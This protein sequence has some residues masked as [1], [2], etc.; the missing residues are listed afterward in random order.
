MNHNV[1]VQGN[2]Q[3]CRQPLSFPN[4]TMALAPSTYDMLNSISDHTTALA[5]TGVAG[6]A[7]RSSHATLPTQWSAHQRSLY[8]QSISA[9]NSH[10]YQPSRTSAIGHTTAPSRGNTGSNYARSPSSTPSTALATA[11]GPSESFVVLDHHVAQSLAALP[12]S[13]SFNTSQ[14]HGTTGSVSPSQSSA[15]AVNKSDL[16]GLT[17]Q[18]SSNA[19]PSPASTATQASQPTA[20]LPLSPHLNQ[21]ANVYSLLSSKSSIDYPL[22]TECIQVL[23]SLMNK[24]LDEG[25][26][27]RERLLAFEKDVLKRRDEATSSAGATAGASPSPTRENLLKEIAKVGSTRAIICRMTLSLTHHD[28]LANSTRKPRIKPLKISKQSKLNVNNWIKRKLSWKKKKLNWRKKSNSQW[29]ERKREEFSRF[30]Q[31]GLILY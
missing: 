16:P 7:T 22:C 27:E 5:T 29:R 9:S 23:L 18:P 20:T 15:A 28:S 3:K 26:K 24:E 31:T 17:G 10:P 13:T 6:E 19:G 4:S 2:C 14:T 21:L 11:I 12:R 30:G 25:K 8:H 1:H